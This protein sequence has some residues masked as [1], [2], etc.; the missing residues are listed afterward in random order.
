[1]CVR[2]WACGDNTATHKAVWEKK[3]TPIVFT[4]RKLETEPTS[5]SK[6]NKKNAL[7]NGERKG[8]SAGIASP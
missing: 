1:M 4:W 7:R 5:L 3:V 2:V 6:G 8:T